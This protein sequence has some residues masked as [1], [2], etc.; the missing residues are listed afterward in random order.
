MVADQMLLL[1]HVVDGRFV[2]L[3]RAPLSMSKLRDDAGAAGGATSPAA[4]GAAAPASRRASRRRVACGTALSLYA[5][6]RVGARARLEMERRRRSPRCWLLSS[7]RR[8]A[9]LR[10][11]PAARRRASGCAHVIYLPPAAGRL[12]TTAARSAGSVDWP[13]RRRR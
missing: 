2:N 9:P 6:R 13:R 4:G 7:P 12:S 5:A 10:R 8:G 11:R 1:M 3:H